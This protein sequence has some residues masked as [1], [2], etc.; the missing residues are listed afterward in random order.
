MRS[1]RIK[2]LIGLAAVVVFF[3]GTLVWWLAIS[4]P[5]IT[6]AAYSQIR[7]G[8]TRGD[9]EAII[10]APPGDYCERDTRRP[11][12]RVVLF[13]RTDTDPPLLE[14]WTGGIHLIPDKEHRAV[15]TANTCEIDIEYDAD[16]RV[17]RKTLRE[18]G[19][20][21]WWRRLIELAGWR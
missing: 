16:F 15:W 1:R 13:S 6:P 18:A 7:L 2:R 11:N 8:M 17:S 10:G 5:R 20:G 4:G 12:G 14:R 9:I 3:A 19:D 21:P